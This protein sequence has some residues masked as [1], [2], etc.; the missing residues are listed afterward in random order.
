MRIYNPVKHLTLYKIAS[1]Q[2]LPIL[3]KNIYIYI[4]IYIYLWNTIQ[5]IAVLRKKYRQIVNL[6]E[7]NAFN[8][9]VYREN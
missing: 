2:L 3:P 9:A 7:Q 4:Y 6:T 1:F 8:I 5:R